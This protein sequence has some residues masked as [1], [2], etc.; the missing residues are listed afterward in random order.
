MDQIKIGKFISEKRKE[1][2][3][4]Q[5][6][7]AE[8]L[9]ISDRAISKWENGICLPDAS[10]MQLLCDILKISINDLFSGEVVDMKDNEKKL[11]ENLL[12]MAKLKEI[13]DKR[14][15]NF[16]ILLGFLGSIILVIL[17]IISAF[18]EMN[19]LLRVLL[20]TI[21]IGTFAICMIYALYIEQV[22]GYYECKKCHHKYIP[23][24]KSVFLAPHVNRTRYMKCPKCNEK[25]WNKK[26]LK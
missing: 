2:N 16:E 10:N 18:I 21:G 7:L 8:K 3:L 20:I 17:I 13:A 19:D 25:S 12:E 14:L 4:T 26:V 5:S 6:E 22:A 24:Y 11:E 1:V 9:N 23:T 15:L